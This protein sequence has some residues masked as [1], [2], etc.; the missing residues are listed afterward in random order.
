MG[1]KVS[2]TFNKQVT[3][4]VF[5]DGYPRTW[6][7]ARERGVKLVSVLWV[8]KCRTAGA[9]VDEALFPAANTHEHLPCLIKKKHRCMQPKDFIPKTPENNKRLQKKFEKMANELQRQ[10][11]TLDQD[12]PVLL[13]ESSGSLVYSPILSMYQGH[14]SAM[15]KRLQ[16]MKEKRE[17]LSPTSS[18][19]VEKSCENPARSFCEASLD[20][21]HDTSCSGDSF[22]GCL[23]LS[24]DDPCGNSGYGNQERESGGCVGDIKSDVCVSSPA[25]KTSSIHSLA[26]P[27][28][29]SHS[30]PRKPVSQPSEEEGNGQRGPGGDVA[31]TP[32]KKPSKGISEMFDAK[33]SLSP[34][35]EDH[36]VG[37]SQPK[38]SS[39]RRKRRSEQLRSPPDDRLGKKRCSRKATVP[40]MQLFQPEGGLWAVASSAVETPHCGG[41][42]YDDY[43]SP[44]NLKERSSENLPPGPQSPSRPAQ[45]GYRVGLSRRERTDILERSDFSR[46]GKNPRS[47][48]TA[49]VTA[50]TSSGLQEPRNDE[51]CAPLG[52]VTSRKT[53]AA[54]EA[55]GCYGQA[56][57]RRRGDGCWEG[58]DFSCP[59]HELARGKEQAGRGHQGGLTPSNKE[60]TEL[61]AAGKQ[62]EDTTSR[63]LN[64]SQGSKNGRTRRDFLEGSW[65]GSKDPVKP[66][67]SKKSWKDRK[68]TRT[69]VMTS[70]SSEKQ[71]IVT[72]VVAK[73][74]GFSL[75]REVCES[76]THVLAGKALRTL[77][78]LLGLARGCWVLS[79]EWVLWSLE[80]GHWISEEP[81]EL[82]DSFP[83]APIRSLSMG[84]APVRTTCC[85]N[86]EMSLEMSPAGSS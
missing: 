51:S 71:S 31:T 61:D 40:R 67:A 13:F 86:D 72:R 27:R 68:P 14:H 42:S 10:K 62:Q 78:V 55:P 8:E 6:E 41:S 60:M 39:V 80:M 35:A 45:L 73:L 77:N 29:L 17:N 24:F 44:D 25:L 3:H 63:M 18:Q 7:K 43:F 19:M 66:E 54:E 83:A 81:F 79:Y 28:Y 36:L 11:T 32:G 22:A 69:L 53:P 48:D 58:N 49:H 52:G 76:T 84:S 74:K 50:N 57:A 5:K 65:G 75:A 26:S 56:D 85:R 12:V 20:I 2:K 33:C 82:S 30:T 46:I 38:S 34:A 21:S 16:E 4:V 59:D 1:A 37:H 9:H 47:V 64:F 23:Q 70:M 15:E